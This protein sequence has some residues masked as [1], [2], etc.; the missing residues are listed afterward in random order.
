MNFHLELSD[1]LSLY[2]TNDDKKR[3]IKQIAHGLK[4]LHDNYIFHRDLKPD[5]IFISKSG[6]MKIADFGFAKEFGTPYKKFTINAC[7]I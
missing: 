3:M 6:W 2:K 5:N 1:L 7:T 4:Y